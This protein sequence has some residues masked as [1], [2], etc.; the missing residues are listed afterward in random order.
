MRSKRKNVDF[1]TFSAGNIDS[2]LSH[3]Q[4]ASKEKSAAGGQAFVRDEE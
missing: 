3:D 2:G 4:S 1:P